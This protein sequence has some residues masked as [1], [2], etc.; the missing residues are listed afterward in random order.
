MADTT[1]LRISALLMGVE[2]ECF[3]VDPVTREAV[4]YAAEVVGKAAEDLGDLVSRELSRYQVETKTPP[5]RTFG[6][7]RGELR[8]LRAAVGTAAEAMGSS[9]VPAGT[10]PLGVPVPI[11]ISEGPRCEEQLQIYR[12]LVHE[13]LICATHV[14][15]GVP[16]RDVAVLMSNHLRP[17]LPLLI[18][19]S[20]NSPFSCGRDT[21]YASWRHVMWQRWPVSGPPP[22]FHDHDE[23]EALLEGLTA[24]GTLA[25]RRT[26]FWDLRLSSRYPTIEVRA[27]DV[28]VTAEESALLAVLV[29]ALALT[30]L[31]DVEEGRPA[32]RPPAEL[33]RAACWRAARDGLRGQGM[34]PHTGR[35]SPAGERVPALLRHI[36]PALEETGDRETV[37]ALLRRL[38]ATGTGADRQRA[39]H[40]RR[41]SLVDV[42]DALVTRDPAVALR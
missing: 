26:V 23:Y 10:F 35:L 22:Y 30:A 19:L 21:G 17:W 13:H 18:A 32:P 8:R 9:P 33:L 15:V 5:C 4:P 16:D 25:D 36:G 31:R 29:R 40:A 7:L 34:D 27:A 14:H 2:E 24:G 38:T 41:G 3:L 11:R 20:A 1:G 6:E 12:G 28:P 39:V 42:V 37:V